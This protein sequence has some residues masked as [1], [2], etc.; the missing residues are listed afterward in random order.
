MM[1]HM[2]L[3]RTGRFKSY[4]QSRWGTGSEFAV[5]LCQEEMTVLGCMDNRV[6][7]IVPVPVTL[8]E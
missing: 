1:E 4:D 3:L 7:G 6:V 8:L 5:T 2:L